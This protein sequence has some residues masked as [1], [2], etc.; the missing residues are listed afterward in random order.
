MVNQTSS[1]NITTQTKIFR[2]SSGSEI[3]SIAYNKVNEGVI[4][5]RAG[6]QVHTI[7][8][9]FEGTSFELNLLL[10]SIK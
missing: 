10:Y 1:G 5:R 2:V 7:S 8:N 4:S 6:N 9:S 3:S